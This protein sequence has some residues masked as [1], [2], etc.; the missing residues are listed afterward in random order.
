MYVNHCQ[1]YVNEG[2][3]GMYVHKYVML[4]SCDYIHY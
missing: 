2:L 4:Q 3:K 1:M